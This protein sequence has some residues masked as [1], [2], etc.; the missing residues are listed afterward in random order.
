MLIN[1]GHTQQTA[2]PAPYAFCFLIG[3]KGAKQKTKTKTTS[4]TKTHNQP[5]LTKSTKPKTELGPSIGL[6]QVRTE[7]LVLY[8]FPRFPSVKQEALT[9]QEPETRSTQR[10]R[11]SPLSGLLRGHELNPIAVL[12]F[13]IT[14][15]TIR[16]WHACF[17]QQPL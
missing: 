5:N 7:S 11:P 3:G 6:M 15:L 12:N 14:E 2:E 16:K 1:P 10:A 9:S 4:T 13:H 17:P 8:Q